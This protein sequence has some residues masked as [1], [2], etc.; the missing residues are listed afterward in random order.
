MHPYLN[1]L[2]IQTDGETDSRERERQR[3]GG[4]IACLW[5]E[6]SNLRAIKKWGR[7]TALRFAF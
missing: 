6:K 2:V 1:L 3:G 4:V 5:S 7:P